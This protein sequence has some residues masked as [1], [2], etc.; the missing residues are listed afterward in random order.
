MGRD[1]SLTRYYVGVEIENM[2]IYNYVDVYLN[3]GQLFPQV[4]VN[5]QRN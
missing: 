5:S 3:E 2:H 4:R 1:N